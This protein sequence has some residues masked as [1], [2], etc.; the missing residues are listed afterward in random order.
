M[1]LRAKAPLIALLAVVTLF[2]SRAGA[3]DLTAMDGEVLQV[4]NEWARIKYQVRDKSEQLREM[5]AL[6]R[7]AGALAGRYP[8][9]AAPLLWKGIATSEEA[10][11]ASVLKQL[12][13][14]VAARKIFEQSEATEP[15]GA[16]GA[17]LMSLG[18]LYYRVPGF[19]MA[20]GDDRLARKDLETA[21]AMDP[22]GLDANYFYGD[23]L[24]KQG[25][26]AKAKTVLAHALRAPRNPQRPIW[27]AGRRAEV[28]GLLGK[29]DR[30]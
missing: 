4:A 11:M 9:Q 22:D 18:V 15:R 23:F 10:G 12:G 7:K 30:R 3:V 16:N 1:S 2:G 29:I 5:D 21:L 27:D 19:P 6:A 17:V 20:F 26:F 28:Q 25:E 8:G 14:A 13:Y 24:V